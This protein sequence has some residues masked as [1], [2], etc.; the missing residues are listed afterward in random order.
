MDDQDGPSAEP[1]AAF[2]CDAC[3][4]A[5]ADAAWRYQRDGCAPT[6]VLVDEPHLT[7]VLRACRACG[8]AFVSVTTEFVGVVGDDSLYRTVVPVTDVERQALL[9]SPVDLRRIGELGA[10][11]RC[12]NVDWPAGGAYRAHWRTGSFTVVEGY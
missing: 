10:D 11:R 1:A 4:H 7:V 3:C 2:G 9:D 5:D 12:L 6:H 8:Q